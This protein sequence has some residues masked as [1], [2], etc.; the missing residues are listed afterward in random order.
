MKRLV[1]L[2]ATVFFCASSAFAWDSESFV[3]DAYS[4]E[5]IMRM[6]LN[7]KL[8]VASD[9]SG[10]IDGTSKD[11]VDLMSLVPSSVT[12]TLSFARNVSY[13]FQGVKYTTPDIQQLTSFTPRASG[14]DYVYLPFP[15]YE[16]LESFGGYTYG[17]LYF[18]AG[19]ISLNFDVT[20]GPTT[21]EF[22]AVLKSYFNSTVDWSEYFGPFNSGTVKLKVNEQVIDSNASTY[23]NGSLIYTSPTPITSISRCI[24]YPTNFALNIPTTKDAFTLILWGG[25]YDSYCNVS[26][27]SGSTVLDSFNDDAQQSINDHESVESQWTGSMTSNFDALDPESFTY[28][29]GL[30]SGFSL[31][32]GIFNDLWNG[33]GEFKIL[34]VFP[35]T[36]G[37]MLLVIG[38]L[39]KFAGGGSSSRKSGDDGA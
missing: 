15:E 19:D 36:L 33:M 26:F 29:D 6:S 28:P 35:L 2:V 18:M 23:R 22:D 25:F 13:T 16:E 34:Y 9:S 8:T 21:V 3:G 30:V 17:D 1:V 4:Y 12:G 11:S 31:I 39:S 24:D 5:P 20:G 38:K 10:S 14:F 32:T 37:I 7:S 27:L